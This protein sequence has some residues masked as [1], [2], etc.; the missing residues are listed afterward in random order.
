MWFW[1]TLST[2]N[3]DSVLFPGDDR[4]RNVRAGSPATHEATVALLAQ[5]TQAPA[6]VV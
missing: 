6:Y 4:A 1:P 5:Q 3:S 2:E